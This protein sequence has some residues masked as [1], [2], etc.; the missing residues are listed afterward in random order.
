MTLKLPQE[1]I[2][3]IDALPNNTAGF[4]HQWTKEEDA[5]LL[6]AWPTKK[7]SD[8]SKLVHMGEDA[9]RRRYAELTHNGV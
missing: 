7:H 1:L 2:D 8:V 9:C 3:K 5:I 4:R 6:Y